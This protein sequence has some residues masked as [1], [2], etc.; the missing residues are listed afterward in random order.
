MNTYRIKHLPSGQYYCPTRWV[1]VKGMGYQKSNL[2]PVG[3]VYPKK[4]T[5]KW[6]GNK[7]Y[8]TPGKLEPFEASHWQIMVIS[9]NETPA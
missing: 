9:N 8:T 5:L 4:P 3:K 6:L 2:S 1:A 7:V